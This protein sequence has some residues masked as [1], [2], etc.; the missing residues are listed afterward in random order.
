MDKNAIKKYA[1]WARRELIARVSQ[2]AAQYEVTEE[3]HENPNAES[4]NG[5]VLSDMERKQR[6]AL[7]KKINES[8]YNQ[9]IEKV[10]YTW[11]N[12]FIA[13]RFMEVN[14]YLPS[15]VRVFTDAE[16]NFKP[17]ILAEAIHLD[18]EGLDKERVFAFKEANDAEGLYK[19]L[20]VTQCNALNKYLPRMF[21]KIDDYTMLLLPDNLLRDG[22]AVEQM[23][24]I[25]PEEDWHDAVQIIGWLY[26]SYIAEPKDERINARKKYVNTDIPFVTQLFTPDWIVKYMVENSLG[27]LWLKKHPN[28]Q[29]KKK[30]IY[31]LEAKNVENEET[32][33]LKPEEIK[34]IDPCAGSGHILVYLFDVLVQIYEAYGTDTRTAVTEIV[35]KNLYGLDIDERAAQLSYFSVMMKACQYDRRFLKRGIQPN[36]YAIEE[37]NRIDRNLVKYFCNNKEELIVNINKM[38]EQMSDAKECGSALI[39]ED[40]DWTVINN[41]LDEIDSEQNITIYSNLISG[42]KKVIRCAQMLDSDYDVVVT[43]PPYMN[44][45]YMPD[46]LRTYVQKHYFD[47]KSD[48][49]SVFTKRATMMAKREGH[50]GLLMPFVWMFIASYENMRR[51]INDNTSI[52]SLIQLE[53]NAFEA[54]CVP[55][56]ALTLENNKISISGE[57]IRLSDFRGFENQEPK[58]LEA[59]S[60]RNCGYRFTTYQE[61]FKKMPGEIIAYWMS[62]AVEH[63][64]VDAEPLASVADIK[65]GLKTGDNNK[66][67]RL[68]YEVDATKTSMQGGGKWFPCNKGGDYRRWYGNNDYVINWENDG[69]ELKNFKTEDGK[70]KSRPQNL[71]Y[72]FREGLTY[73]NIS[74]SKFGIRYCPEGHAFDAAGSMIFAKKDNI[75]YLL[76]LL[77]S[78]IIKLFTSILSPTMSFEVGQISVIPFVESESKDVN[79]LVQSCIEIAKNDWDSFETSWN[80]KKHPLIQNIE[81]MQE[82]FDNWKSICDS[83]IKQVKNNEERINEIFIDIYNMKNDVSPVVDENDITIRKADLQR[84]IKSF[85]SYAVGCMFGRYSLDQEGIIYAGGKWDNSKYLTIQA[86]ED[87]IIPICDDEYFEDDIVNRFIKFVE[88]VYGEKHLQDNLRFIADALGG[89]G[90]PKEIIRNYFLTEFYNDHCNM[91]SITGSGKRPYYWLF[92]SGKKNG[93]KCLIYMH[94]YQPDTIARIR[95][96]YVHEQQSRYRTT[97]EELEQRITSASTSERVKINKQLKTV[98]DQNTE[99]HEYEEK[100][101]HLADQMISIDLDDGVKANYAK[102]QDVLAKIK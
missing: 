38:L 60:N 9:V 39:I 24:T 14:G 8:S 15:R 92:D 100:I 80:F 71:Q 25:I 73:T 43:N 76:G 87:N 69:F 83:R 63:A 91:C 12:R 77:S 18:M 53:Y 6:A 65:Q 37:S 94:R 34:C 20:L 27:R 70:L 89:K 10:A 41:R 97:I 68:W 51:Y 93:F 42:L 17:E 47:Y 56:A 84:D 35:Q 102:F 74:S 11:F 23:I 79:E 50:I 88:V 54:A 40:I 78:N 30:W 46:K 49:F 33:I 5:K 99:I 3:S 44:I 90:Q 57:Y 29:L 81:L 45:S 22:S 64:F 1:V 85:I 4:V 31:Y 98:Q 59:I 82:A 55:V 21:E 2:K 61:L 96:D 95:T 67:L 48:L 13:L 32:S 26:Q 19:Y 101:H 52:T 62:D 36:I 7:I 75:L 58:V 16:N 72:Q 28:E 86:D 66:F